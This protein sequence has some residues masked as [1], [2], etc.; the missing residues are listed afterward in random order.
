MRMEM[1][2]VVPLS[3]M[4]AGEAGRVIRTKKGIELKT[5]SWV[6][7]VSKDINRVHVS[8]NGTKISLKVSDA[9]HVLVLIPFKN[10]I[11]AL[12]AEV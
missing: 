6:E 8:V 5:G 9:F 4:T 12:R 3:Y 2:I 7:V 1:G 11:E 10:A